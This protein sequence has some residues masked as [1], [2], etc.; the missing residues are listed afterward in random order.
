MGRHHDDG[1]VGVGTAAF[2]DRNEEHAG[3]FAVTSTADDQ[4]IGLLGCLDEGCRWR[5]LDDNGLQSETSQSLSAAM[6][7]CSGL[8]RGVSRLRWSARHPQMAVVS[9]Q[10]PAVD[11][12]EMLEVGTSQRR[13]TSSP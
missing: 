5:A 1:A 2:A 6:S 10:E 7:P 11:V 13:Q 9:Q 4:K 8:V 12:P 3:W